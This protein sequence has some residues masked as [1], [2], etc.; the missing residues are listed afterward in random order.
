MQNNYEKIID[1]ALR[2]SVFFPSAEIY[3]TAFSGFYDY[4]P[5]GEAIKRKIIDAWRKKLVQ[6]E[7]FLE[8]D[9]A[10]ILPEK[11]FDASG[12]LKNFNDPLVQCTKCHSL[13]R[14]DNLLSDHL[15][16][17]FPE[18]M[19]AEHF[20]EL[21]KKNKP[22]CPKCKGELGG[23]KR[24]NMMLKVQVG[25]T[26]KQKGFLRPE[27]C[28]NIFLD[29]D[30]L[31]KTMRLNLPFG[32]AQAGKSFRNEIAP[33]NMLLREREINQ[34]EIEVFFNP[35]KINEIKKFHELESKKLNI[36]KLKEEK[37]K[38]VSAKELVEKNIVSGKLIAY[39]LARVQEL[40]EF[41]GVPKEK[42]KFRQ[43][44]E[45]EKA[46]YA[47]EAWDFEIL[48]SLGWIELIAC[49]YRSDYDLKGHAKES[50]RNLKTKEDGEEFYPNV[51]ELSAGIDRTLYALLELALR[52]E[53]KKGEARLYLDLKPSIAPYIAGI[54]PLV[55]KDGLDEKAEKLFE[56]LKSYNLDLFYDDSGS[57]GRRY[58]RIDE[59]GV[60]FAITIDYDSMKDDTVT[61]RERNSTQQKRIAV[62]ELPE[63]LW[64]LEIGKKEFKDL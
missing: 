23:V 61:L 56:E 26:G 38:E 4:G 15:N 7:G 2:R 20:D 17:N 49:N 18:S 5:V 28:Q 57:I 37:P 59:I 51:F 62:K 46:F 22:K 25:A 21:I 60:P 35:K 42:M 36:Q 58:A 14:A 39:Y 12:H 31:S 6:R 19:P 48:T 64:K 9:G 11:V 8:V 29:Y 16:V 43:L 63:L 1:L 34:M 41:Y 40:Y 33:R 55:N 13:Y 44:G 10:Q 27:T 30:R 54:L 50:S 45:E 24:F 3:G 32:I 47:K 53:T 52:E